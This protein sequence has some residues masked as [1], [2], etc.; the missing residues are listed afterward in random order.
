MATRVEELLSAGNA[1]SGRARGLWITFVLFGTYLI[2]AIGSTTHRQMLLEQPL[3][4]PILGA[5][6]NLIDF[7]RFAPFLFLVFHFYMLVQFYLLA[8]TL[9]R[10]DEHI[11]TDLRLDSE[12]RHL[13]AQTDKFLVTQLLVGRTEQ[14][15]PR[16]FIRLAAWMTMVAAPVLLL[17]AF[18]VRFLPYHDV[19][20]TWVQRG[21]LLVDLALV[22]LLW[23]VIAHRSGRI[24]GVIAA[25]FW[26]RPKALYQALRAQQLQ[27][28]HQLQ[29]RQWRQAAGSFWQGYRE[30]RDATRSMAIDALWAVGLLWLS[31]AVAGFSLLVATVPAED[32]ERW[33]LTD[34]GLA[35]RADDAMKDCVAHDEEIGWAWTW[36]APELVRPEPIG[37]HRCHSGRVALLGI[38]VGME[39]W[40][41]KRP[42]DWP[43]PHDGEPNAV[44]WPTAILFEGEPDRASSKVT[45]LFSR[46]LVLIDDV[47]LVT[48]SDDELEQADR[49]LVL[50]GRDLRYARFDRAD[51]RKADLFKARLT[52]AIL[53]ETQIEGVILEEAQMQGAILFRAEMQGANLFRTE[54]QGANLSGAEMQGTDLTV[55]KLQGADL[56][57]AKMQ[58]ANLSVAEMQGAN[59]YKAEMQGADLAIAEMQGADLSFAKM[60]GAD[61]S[62]AKMQGANLYK[63]E[64]QGADLAAAEMQG[65]N[66]YGAALWLATARSANLYLADDRDMTVTDPFAEPDPAKR[67]AR[68]S[69]AIEGW[70]A[71]IPHEDVRKSA[72]ERLATLREPSSLLGKRAPGAWNPWLDAA[73]LPVV[74]WTQS[75]EEELA[76]ALGELG[77]DAGKAP[78]I[79]RGLLNRVHLKTVLRRHRPYQP[80]LATALLAPDCAGARGLTEEERA[81]LREIAAR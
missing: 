37:V 9:H 19:F 79:A 76:I 15:L 70:L 58:G 46:N 2:I 68:A 4:L 16:F 34:W 52:G 13:R 32:I 40:L 22:W 21:C 11:R 18:Q 1:A 12:R 38:E 23:P 43:V 41:S 24:G 65:A 50:R 3:V 5:S 49:T 67:A 28:A 33:L 42:R 73:S 27:T 80:M 10:L 45:S 62:F 6:L 57:F 61:L 26:E 63:A 30:A 72:L 39:P 71:E 47:D 64:M 78:D 74:E 48:L 44:W 20:T 69:E 31:A 66:L 8:G 75:T 60:Q 25:L 55:A 59:L 53:E 7:Y 56:S 17:L 54:M 77:C 36:W 14:W 81:Q 29:A 35:A 51:I